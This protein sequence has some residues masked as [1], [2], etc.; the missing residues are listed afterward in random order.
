[1]K[2]KDGNFEFSIYCINLC[3][4]Y[5]SNGQ[6]I[7]MHLLEIHFYYILCIKLLI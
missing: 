4:K 1:M 6:W 5:V 3:I 7:F 2:T